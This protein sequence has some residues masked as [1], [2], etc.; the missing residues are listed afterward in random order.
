MNQSI[1]TNKHS[2]SNNS[3]LLSDIEIGDEEFQNNQ[4]IDGSVE[5]FAD[6]GVSLSVDKVKR[7]TSSS[8][9]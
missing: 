9:H 1:I 4:K 5:L 3:L 8:T 2:R 7:V 6:F